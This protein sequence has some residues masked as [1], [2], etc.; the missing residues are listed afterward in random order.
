MSVLRKTF[1]RLVGP[2]SLLLLGDTL[3]LD[4]WRWLQ[5]RLPT[6]PA[7]LIDVGCGNG[8][9]AINC[10]LLGYRTLGIGWAGPDLEKAKVRGK[11]FGSDARFEVQDVRTL[12]NRYDLKQCFDVATCLETIEHILDDAKVMHSLAGVLRTGGTLILTTPSQEYIPMGNGDAGPFSE[13]E[14]GRHVRKGYTPERLSHLAEQAG[15]KVTEIGFCSGWASQ[16][17]TALLR[18][19]DRH[20][21]YAPAWAVT[22]PLRLFPP[23]FDNGNRAYPRYSI[24]MQATKV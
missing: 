6:A 14:D 12:S 4:R 17:A 13:V 11:L 15:F 18:R 1:I 22:L 3:V 23:L 9:L 7:S 16:R 21:G 19:L 5:S 24:C 20:I 2:R 8:W 10:S